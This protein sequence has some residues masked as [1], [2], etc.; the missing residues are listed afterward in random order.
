VDR[1]VDMDNLEEL[2]AIDG[3]GMLEVLER[4]P[5]QVR[6]ALDI[7][8]SDVAL[9]SP[10]DVNA[11]VVLGMG[12]SGI[13]GDV[14]SAVAADNGLPLPVITVKGYSLPPL[15]DERTLVFAVSYSGNTEETLDCFEQALGRGARL[16]A[17]SSGGRLM[18]FAGE[19]GVPCFEIPGGLQPRAS[20][21]YLFIPVVS[22]ME[23]MGMLSGVTAEL[24]SAAGMLDERSREYRVEVPLDGNPPKRLAR[25]LLGYVPVVYGAEGYV[26]VAAMRWKAQFNENAKIPSF[27]NSF[28]E[29]NH[30][31]TVGWKNDAEACSRCQ[32][33]LLRAPHEHPRVE[34]RML[35]TMELLRD[36]VGHITQVYARGDNSIERLMDLIYFGDY[37]SVYLALALGQ[38]PTPVTRIEEL[39]KKLAAGQA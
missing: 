29:L 9:P 20:L 6:D 22:A 5:G 37:T 39:K 2:A 27:H 31:E 11:V 17:V 15:V 13:S 10:D 26:A 23:R 33:I 30:N 8:G 19:H 36:S 12:G 35:I 7:G 24:R 18:E 38:D 4:F 14:A 32:L 21:G 3:S 28:P 1:T 34:K 16:V 25:D